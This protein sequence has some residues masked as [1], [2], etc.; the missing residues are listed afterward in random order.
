MCY[1]CD[2]DLWILMNSFETEKQKIVNSYSLHA[3]F[4]RDVVLLYSFQR[5]FSLF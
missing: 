1:E 3:S 5:H 4:S 2:G